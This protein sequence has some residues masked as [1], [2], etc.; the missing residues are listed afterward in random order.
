MFP[1]LKKEQ[2][3]DLYG[4]QQLT[5]AAWVF[6]DLWVTFAFGAQSICGLSLMDHVCLIFNILSNCLQLSQWVPLQTSSLGCCSLSDCISSWSLPGRQTTTI[7][8]HTTPLLLA[9]LVVFEFCF[10]L[11]EA[12]NVFSVDSGEPAAQIHYN[13]STLRVS[14]MLRLQA[15]GHKWA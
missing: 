14:C 10:I 15:E 9:L 6:V 7:Q 5:V 4:F 2:S 11:N 1:A 13:H 3:W 8:V 12:Q